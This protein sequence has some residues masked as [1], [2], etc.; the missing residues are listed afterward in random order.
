MF[1]FPTRNGFISRV[2]ISKKRKKNYSI[3]GTLTRHTCT[4]DTLENDIRINHSKCQAIIV[5]SK[6][7][8]RCEKPSISDSDT[9]E[10]F[11]AT[12]NDI[13][14]FDKKF[15]TQENSSIGHSFRVY[16]KY[17]FL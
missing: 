13:L 1:D 2:T 7:Q 15:I 4:N 9:P 10:M 16:V 5:I 11:G 6:N 8:F 17:A 3:Q 14:K 12:V